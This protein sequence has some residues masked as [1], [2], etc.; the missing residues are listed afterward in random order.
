MFLWC[1]QTQIRK[2]NVKSSS[3]G[4][5]N[6]FS[7]ISE[8]VKDCLKKTLTYLSAGVVAAQTRGSE[9]RAGEMFVFFYDFVCVRKL[10]RCRR[11]RRTLG[12]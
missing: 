10:K 9:R 8:F 6:E 1:K 3:E 7:C 4:V 11:G 12:L 2:C 5:N